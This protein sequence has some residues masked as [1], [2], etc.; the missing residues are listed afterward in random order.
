M[1]IIID[2]HKPKTFMGLSIDISDMKKKQY[3]LDNLTK[4]LL[5]T[6]SELQKF[7]YITSHNLRAPIVNLESLLQFYDYETSDVHNHEIVEKMDTS[8]KRLK[9]TLDDLVLVVSKKA[10]DKTY[11]N[12]D[13]EFELYQVLNDFQT[14]IENSNVKIE[15]DFN[16]VD[17]LVYN[18]KRFREIFAQLISNSLKFKS[19]Q[20][21][22]K[23]EFKSFD[24][25]DYIA[26]EICD[27]GTGIDL[28]KNMGKMFG[29]Y[30]RF[31]PEVEGKGSGLFILKS[32]IESLDGKIEVKS[33]L[34]FGTT[35]TVFF[36]K[37][38][39]T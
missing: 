13:I 20:R 21:P 24:Y 31:H 4:K 7:A 22:L 36:R 6:N 29:L 34:N 33:K 8:T 12:V 16:E 17:K 26:I 28:D 5:K 27:N 3:H 19:S 30:Q 25:I 32:Q 9:D 18:T 2:N 14:D 39:L 1:K 11:E 10:E 37:R 23:I 38:T 15:F 35:F